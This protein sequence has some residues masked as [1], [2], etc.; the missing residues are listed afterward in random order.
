MVSYQKKDTETSL[1][2]NQSCSSGLWSRGPQS[3]LLVD[4]LQ[5]F[6]IAYLKASACLAARE[7]EKPCG[8]WNIVS[9]L[10]VGV[11]DL[12][13]DFGPV[14]NVVCHCEQK[15]CSDS[16]VISILTLNAGQMLCLNHKREGR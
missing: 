10:T 5:F 6:N 1:S 11:H 2:F 3:A 15:V 8:N 16:L 14:Y 12:T 7:K 13:M 9:S 4:E